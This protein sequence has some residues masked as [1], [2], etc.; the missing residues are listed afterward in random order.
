MY[1][2]TLSRGAGGALRADELEDKVGGFSHLSPEI[3][4]K[5]IVYQM[6]KKKRQ[7]VLQNTKT[8]FKKLY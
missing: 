4:D 3:Y 5:R 2:S 1:R 6:L 8:I 7:D